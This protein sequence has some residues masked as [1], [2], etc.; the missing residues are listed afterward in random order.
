M[1]EKD[2]QTRWRNSN[3]VRGTV[4]GMAIA[5]ET[6]VNKFIAK[7]FCSSKLKQREMIEYLLGTERMSFDTKR[8][9]METII[10]SHLP[11]LYESRYRQ[12][13]RDIELRIIP[14]RNEFAHGLTDLK[15]ETAKHTGLIKYKKGKVNVIYS[16][17]EI[18]ALL[19]M[20]D[21]HTGAI[22]ELL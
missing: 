18:Q 9:L 3:M 1:D 15:T 20:I 22:T 19:K 5:L 7:H 12:I 4:I 10:Q 21:D 14:K 17:E 16:Y 6:V 13:L 11:H 8:Q 2:L